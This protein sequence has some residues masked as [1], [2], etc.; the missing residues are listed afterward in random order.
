VL[1]GGTYY[2]RVKAAQSANKRVRSQSMLACLRAVR[3]R[4]RAVCLTSKRRRREPNDRL[5]SAGDL[6]WQGRS[7]LASGLYGWRRDEDWY[8]L[9][10]DAV[11]RGGS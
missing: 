1:P 4:S 7:A 11:N 3:T 5:E 9:S 6:L 8:R 10:L 2:L